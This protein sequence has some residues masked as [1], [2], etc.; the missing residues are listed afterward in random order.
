MPLTFV[1]VQGSCD[2]EFGIIWVRDQSQ[3]IH[4]GPPDFVL[5]LTDIKWIKGR[6]VGIA[7]SDNH[8]GGAT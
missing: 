3:N 4:I 6:S 5:L 7:D 1:F 2:R 8:L